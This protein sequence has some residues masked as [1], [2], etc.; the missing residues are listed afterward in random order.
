MLFSW[1]PWWLFSGRRVSQLS[2]GGLLPLSQESRWSFTSPLTPCSAHFHHKKLIVNFCKRSP[3]RV[4]DYIRKSC[5]CF[6]LRAPSFDARIAKSVPTTLFGFSCHS[7][8]WGQ[9]RLPVFLLWRRHRHWSQ[10]RSTIPIERDRSTTRL[11]ELH[12]TI[13]MADRWV[14][15]Y[16]SSISEQYQYLLD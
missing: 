5:P 6:K 10:A 7:T 1:S 14:R 4:A 16:S 8:G 15:L 11:L 3:L 9:L 12:A 2:P 13:H